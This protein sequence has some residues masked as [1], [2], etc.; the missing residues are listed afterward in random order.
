MGGDAVLNA[1]VVRDLVSGRPGP[2]QDIVLLNAAAGL[3]ADAKP[4]ADDLTG[5]LAAQLSR[6]RGVV[7]SGA[8]QAKLDEWVGS[9]QSMR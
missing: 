6:A 8:A 9:T 5:Q 7:A 3:V 1:Q 2:V 4:R